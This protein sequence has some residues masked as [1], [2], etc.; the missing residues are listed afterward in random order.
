MVSD[1]TRDSRRCRPLPIARLRDMQELTSI[2]DLLEQMVPLGASD[3][4]PQ[5][6]KSRGEL[7]PPHIRPALPEYRGALVLVTGP[8]GWG[9]GRTLAGVID[10]ITRT[11]SDH[12]L[13]VEAPIEFVHR[14]KKCIVN[15]REI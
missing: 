5:E 3:L 15:Q 9:R 4:L 7:T 6:T 2:D 1:C 8:T 14:H 10:E 13:R 11:R 12:T